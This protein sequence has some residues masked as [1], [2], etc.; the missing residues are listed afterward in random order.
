MKKTILIILVLVMVIGSAFADVRFSGA[1]KVLWGYDF[2]NQEFTVSGRDYAS[3]RET[4]NYGKIY[5]TS[6][7]ANL[8]V[9]VVGDYFSFNFMGALYS[10]SNDKEGINA[11]ITLKGKTLLKEAGIELNKL[12][13]L[14]FLIGNQIIRSN[15]VYADPL[16]HDDGSVQLLLATNFR[17]L[18][19]GIEFGTKN[20]TAKVAGTIIKDHEE[21]GGN[22]RVKLFEGA[23]WVEAGYSYNN[24]AEFISTTRLGHKFDDGGNGHRFGASASVDI[25]KFLGME[26]KNIILSGDVQLNLND[27]SQKENKNANAY[28]GAVVFKTEKF[29][30]GAEYRNVPVKIDSWDGH[31]NDDTRTRISAVEGKV[32]YTFVENNLK[33]T[34]AATAGYMLSRKSLPGEPIAVDDKGFMFSVSGQITVLGLNVKLGYTFREFEPNKYFGT[35][36]AYFELNFKF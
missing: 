36:K 8:T 14:D 18:P 20:W 32:S 3:I 11:R 12:D 24:D 29:F 26:N 9:K 31:I 28:F 6:A 15:K 2:N 21:I 27:E 1:A 23:L 4:Y 17:Y 33:P 25:A 7:A 19:A 34:L 13:Q 30:F 16:A 22:L 5:N 35:S 10:R